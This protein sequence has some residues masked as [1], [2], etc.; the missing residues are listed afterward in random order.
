MIKLHVG[1]WHAGPLVSWEK[2]YGCHP[3]PGIRIGVDA[4]FWDV[5]TR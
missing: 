1:T 4:L 5:S 3:D 2:Q